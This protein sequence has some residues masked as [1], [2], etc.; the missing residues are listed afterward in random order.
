MLRRFRFPRPVGLALLLGLF[1]AA[2]PLVRAQDPNAPPPPAP[3]QQ[4]YPQQPQDQQPPPP[5]PPNQNPYPAE[6]P[7][8][9]PPY[10]APQQLDPLVQRIALYPDPLL[11]QI[12]TAA[13][14][15]EQIPSAAG[16]ADQHAG[17]QGPALAQAIQEDNLQF[18]PS[19]MALLPFPQ[20]LDMMARDPN[21]TQQLGSAVLAQRADVM[22]AIQR[23][24]Q[25]AY[26]YGYLRSSPY[27]NV[28]YDGNYVQ[29]VPVNPAYLYVPYYDPAVVFYRPRPGFNVGFG[30]RFGPAIVLGEPFRPW[31]WGGI[32]F[33]W[34]AHSIMIDRTPWNRDWGNRAYYVH[35]Y[36]H[37]I[38]RRPGPPVEHHDVHP[39]EHR[40]DHK[41]R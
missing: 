13:T 23:D 17:I 32:G 41:P 40:D 3:D 8:A 9:P 14:V 22:D 5:P 29:I 25:Q 39:N 16:W 34:G 15:W 35:P 7:Q 21:W 6:P 33:A 27:D 37:G 2:A 30:I 4:Q 19:V 24:R 18:D 10:L 28:I 26:A 1:L 20:V 38:E 12:L 36:Q 31:G 11:A